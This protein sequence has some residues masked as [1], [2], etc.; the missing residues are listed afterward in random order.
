MSGL[1]GSVTGLIA[2]SDFT[3][4]LVLGGLFIASIFCVAI[5][6]LKLLFFSKEMR[7]IKKLKMRVKGVKDF[8]DYLLL[9]KE[10]QGTLSGYF[11][12]E[13]LIELRKLLEN[14]LSK[15]EEPLDIGTV[16]QSPIF[17]S[18][19][20]IAKF[21]ETLDQIVD[22]IL[23]E[24]EKY[25]PILGTSAAVAPLVG[26]FGTIWGL[27]HAFVRISQLKTADIAVV[28]PGIAEALL[29][30]LAGL[31]VAIPAMIF[32]HYFSNKLRKLEGH[33]IIVAASF[34]DSV[35]RIFIKR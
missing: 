13:A 1:G 30:T 26:L 4:W 6:I 32:F 19:E 11:I 9:R 24:G 29:T 22:H 33:I 23:M 35:R 34:F 5:I 3:T 21:D 17:L 15:G 7:A 12:E 14:K 28:A 20:D 8:N 27:C 10:F 25:L 16:P 2:L 18:E 31:V